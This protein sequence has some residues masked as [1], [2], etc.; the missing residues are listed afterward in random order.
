MTV[1][2]HVGAFPVEELVVVI[3]AAWTVMAVRV[4]GWPNR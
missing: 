2:A 3:S 1:L 4:R